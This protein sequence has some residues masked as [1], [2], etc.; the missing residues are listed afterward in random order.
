MKKLLIN[1]INFLYR[2]YGTPDVIG[3]T[4]AQ[5]ELFQK[6]IDFS[7]MSKEVQER[8]CREAKNLLSNHVLQNVLNE[9][10]EGIKEGIFF[11]TEEK[12]IIYDRFSINGIHLIKDKLRAYA[13]QIE[14]EDGDFDKYGAI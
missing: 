8:Y 6:P 4:R 9:T 2:K 11:K 13:T 1:L 7:S 5:L 12:N 3:M 10:V 14:E